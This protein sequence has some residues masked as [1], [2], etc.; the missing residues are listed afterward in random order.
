MSSSSS[1]SDS[2]H[3]V[4]DTETTGLPKTIKR[5]VYFPPYDTAKYDSARLVSIAWV[6]Y[7]SK[8]NEE[9]KRENHLI[10]PDK[11]VKIEN[12]HIHG[13]TQKMAEEKGEDFGVVADK[14]LEDLRK[15]PGPMVAY[16]ALFDANV[17]KAELVRRDKVPMVIFMD[18]S[19]RFY[20]A[21]KA[22]Q[23]RWWAKGNKKIP[24]LA[25][26]HRF[27]VGKDFEGT[28]HDALADTIACAN[29]WHKLGNPKTQV[30]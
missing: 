25:E 4:F 16:N 1:S 15:Y 6:V 2:Y 19:V 8:T 14:L 20:C 10:K 26:A 30:C 11:D 12:S 18:E 23:Y 24:R 21:M 7:K 27:V 29:I 9:V 5:G 17:L 28:Q 22:T 13:I 3:F